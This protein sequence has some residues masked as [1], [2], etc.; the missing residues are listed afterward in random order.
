MAAMVYIGH[1]LTLSFALMTS[2]AG[3]SL[4]RCAG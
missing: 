4:N 3:R 1:Y 2:I